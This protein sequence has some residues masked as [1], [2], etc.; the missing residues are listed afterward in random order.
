MFQF[1]CQKKKFYQ[2]RNQ[3]ERTNNESR[4]LKLYLN[5]QSPAVFAERRQHM[6]T[7]TNIKK[8]E[9][10]KEKLHTNRMYVNEKKKGVLPFI[11]NSNV[12]I[13]IYKYI[14]V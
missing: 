6:Y 9:E 12:Y 5:W 7:F 4:N 11:E 8:N 10:R 14:V 1:F 2:S 3:G 13:Y